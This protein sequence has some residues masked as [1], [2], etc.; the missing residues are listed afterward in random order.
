MVE[1]R[2][3]IAIPQMT[4]LH[5]K[6]RLCG[7]W[8][9]QRQDIADMFKMIDAGSL[10]LEDAGGDQLVGGSVLE[11]RKEAWVFCAAQNTVRECM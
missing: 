1:Y 6:R 9:Y 11:Q 8:M 4:I 10:R 3:D 7:K 2:E 5:E